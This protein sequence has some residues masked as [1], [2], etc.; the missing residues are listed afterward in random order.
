MKQKNHL[1]NLN[2]LLSEMDLEGVPI[3]VIDD[4]AD[5]AGLNNKVNK[6]EISTL[7][8]HL[9]Q[10]R[11]LSHTSL[12]QYTA[13]PQAPLLINI[14][15]VLSPD[16]AE[17]LTPG[18]D[19]IGGKEFFLEENPPL[20]INIPST[21]IPTD[22]N[23]VVEAPETF[24]KALMLFYL[25]VASGYVLDRGQGNRSMMVHPSRKTAPHGEYFHW[26]RGISHKWKETLNNDSNN[27]ERKDLLDQFETVYQ[28]L[29]RTVSNLPLFEELVPVLYR[30]INQTNIQE[31]NAKKG[32]TP[33]IDWRNEYAH[34]LIGGEAMDRG[35]TVEGLTVTYMP[36][37]T[38]MGNADS[39]QQRAR[40]F[41]YK[42]SY[43]GYCRVFLES[44]VKFAFQNYVKHEEYIRQQ[45]IDNRGQ[46]LSEWKRLFFLD[47]GLKPTRSE[48]LD[49][50]YK[51]EKYSNKWYIPQYICQNTEDLI[52]SNNE[53][54]N[55]FWLTLKDN[56]LN[57]KGFQNN[58]K[59]IL[60]DNH[61]FAVDIPI[62]NL[63]EQLLVD[64]K[65][66]SPEESLRFS[67]LILLIQDYLN[68]YPAELCDVYLMNKGDFRSR[69]IPNLKS[70]L[71]QPVLFQGK[72]DQGKFNSNPIK[73]PGDTKI[74]EVNKL[75]VQIHRLDF[76]VTD[77]S[78][79]PSGFND[80]A[81]LT[82]WIPEKMSID[83]VYQDQS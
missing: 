81:I 34:I 42:R 58:N 38:G 19:Y 48:V 70:K 33:P 11:Q 56:A 17:V 65:I 51:R 9:C 21:E 53:A 44:D 1:E 24:L 66:K 14:A 29:V 69:T 43:F 61:L 63:L 47:R 39:I 49:I 35:F 3:L 23:P 73:Y 13:T 16:F 28:E 60:V 75:T 83:L 77:E 4:E 68:Q 30:S 5:R 64:Y 32:K 31:V 80:F 54:V 72:T 55:K 37:G 41:G 52:K 40:F 7:Y 67:G 25:G 8:S 46:P 82:I 20:V 18:E 12:L 10:L 57:Q 79:T 71:S 74:K 15:D 22:H 6:N 78:Y 2:S 27:P 76:K 26:T 62:K 36:R 59:Q 50:A 45:L